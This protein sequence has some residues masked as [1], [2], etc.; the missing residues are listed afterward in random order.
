MS[1]SEVNF[2]QFIHKYHMFFDVND[3]NILSMHLILSLSES[4]RKMS[5][6]LEAIEPNVSLILLISDTIP[7]ANVCID[8]L[9]IARAYT[10]I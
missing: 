5:H 9:C 4:L 3:S 2:Q 1:S 7:P 8:Y 10:L 6:F